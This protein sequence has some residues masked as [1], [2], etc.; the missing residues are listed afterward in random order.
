MR[1][2]GALTATAIALLTL[3]ACGGSDPAPVAAPTSTEPAAP[4]AQLLVDV[5]QTI[6]VPEAF[7]G[8]TGFALRTGTGVEAPDGLGRDTW[9]LTEFGVASYVAEAGQVPVIEST[10]LTGVSRWRAE[11][12][13]PLTPDPNPRLQPHLYS[14]LGE[15]RTWLAV[16]EYGSEPGSTE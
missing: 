11:V 5:P 13:D 8:T 15:D 3:S 9:E 4:N 2:T 14:V 16:V 6:A 12:T 10:T 1:R 7:A